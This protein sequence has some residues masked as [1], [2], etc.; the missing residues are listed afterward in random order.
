M[1]AGAKTDAL[2]ASRVET[3]Y[4]V[5][6]HLRTRAL[7]TPGVFRVT[8]NMTEVRDL[9]RRCDEGS[10]TCLAECDDNHM[11]AGLLLEV[12][13]EM[14]TSLFDFEDFL[15]LQ[16]PGNFADV[17][18][19]VCSY[20]AERRE[21]VRQVV[22]LLRSL[23]INKAANEV[24]VTHLVSIFSP[25]LCRPPSG[26][27]MS[28]RHI[29]ALPHIQLAL[30]TLI[31]NYDLVFRRQ[32]A[33]SPQA[34]AESYHNQVV[35]LAITEELLDDTVNAWF[36][37]D[38]GGVAPP[39][40]I[41]GEPARWAHSLPSPVKAQQQPAGAGAG[42]GSGAGAGAGVEAGSAGAR[43]AQFHLSD[44]DAFHLS[45]DE[46]GAGGG[47]DTSEEKA[48]GRASSPPSEAKH[49]GSGGDGAGG[50]GGTGG[51]DGDEDA[52]GNGGKAAEGSTSA[53][54]GVSRSAA[55]GLSLSISSDAKTVNAP[56]SPPTPWVASPNDV[57]AASTR[58]E[59]VEQTRRPSGAL[60][61]KQVAEYRK[62][63]VQVKR[64]EEQ[65]KAQHGVLPKGKAR[66]P[67]KELYNRYRHLKQVVRDG[68]A[69]HIQTV[70][71]GF[72]VRNARRSAAA[73]DKGATPTPVSVRRR[74]SGSSEV[75]V[76]DRD[77]FG[78]SGGAGTAGAGS[79]AESV[80]SLKAAKSKLKKQLKQFDV[81][82]K[83]KHGRLPS[84]E[85]KEP[86]RHLYRRYAELKDA[87]AELEA[88]ASL[89]KSGPAGGGPSPSQDAYRALRREK[90]MLQLKLKTY[91]DE[92][93]RLTG[94]K[95]R[96]H[97]DIRPVE[98][99]YQRYKEVKAAIQELGGKSGSP[100][101]SP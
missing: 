56:V 81:D 9:L 91:E 44:V 84:N 19:L 39:V 24:N 22:H 65:Y 51:T 4:R 45:D 57:A 18:K 58:L 100:D 96:Y 13:R 99:E 85:D 67:A 66:A 1:S 62:V 88:E 10:H 93:Q 21:M 71:R 75:S 17:G 12:L 43:E 101:N 7:Y 35:V 72:R 98:A 8:A 46:D 30:L 54:R 32:R 97:K 55:Q 94:R 83:A 40:Q 5:I 26:A 31:N 37:E 64:F 92:F 68:S 53:S 29:K 15:A 74:G 41:T 95:V 52:D 34:E 47:R 36:E 80:P 49:G 27:F 70:Y 23:H 76:I 89:A 82:F 59:I 61:R 2:Q 63:R 78:D 50:S 16:Q 48:G 33:W 79:A 86:I 3:M 73:D 42:V 6:E 90:R 20:P 87:I 38:D 28:I 77:A 69:L 14:P 25:V 60:R 11:I